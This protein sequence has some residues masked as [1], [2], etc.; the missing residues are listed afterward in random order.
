MDQT[1]GL[2]PEI[3]QQINNNLPRESLAQVDRVNKNLHKLS[4]ADY[5]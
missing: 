1:K 5:R 2:P 3:W 4:S